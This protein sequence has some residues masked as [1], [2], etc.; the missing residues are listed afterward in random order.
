VDFVDFRLLLAERSR[1][2]LFEHRV[3]VARL[4][5]LGGDDGRWCLAG[6]VLIGRYRQC[7]AATKIK[8]AV[9]TVRR[10]AC[11]DAIAEQGDECELRR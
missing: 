7:K 1:V 11:D 2:V 4:D 5:E 9:L 10:H 6:A 3:V 8:L